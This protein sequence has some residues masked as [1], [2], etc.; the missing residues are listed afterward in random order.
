MGARWLPNA[1]ESF[2][3]VKWPFVASF[4]SDRKS[5]LILH[6]LVLDI[7]VF[8]KLLGQVDQFKALTST[9]YNLHKAI[10]LK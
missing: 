3:C 10:F 2:C 1:Q 6:I 8:S 9:G 5:V 4:C 7:K